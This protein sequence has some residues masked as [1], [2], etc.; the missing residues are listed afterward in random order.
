MAVE[1]V[2]G[3]GE[4]AFVFFLTSFFFFDGLD[5]EP[6]VLHSHCFAFFFQG[7]TQVL[8]LACF[9]LQPLEIGLGFLGRRPNARLIRRRPGNPGRRRLVAITLSLLI[10]FV[11]GFLLTPVAIAIHRFVLLG[12]EWLPDSEQL[13]ATMKL[14]RRGVHRVYADVIDSLYE[15]PPPPRPRSP[16][17][18]GLV[19]AG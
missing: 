16:E 10:G 18:G 5:L 8:G 14:K 9:G 13:T 1:I 15:S 3:L 12:E 7:E 6:G 11:Q 2:N 4:L 19:S 17:E